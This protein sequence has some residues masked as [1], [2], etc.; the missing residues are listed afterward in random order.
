MNKESIYSVVET[1]TDYLN[2][3]LL[4]QSPKLYIIS[5]TWCLAIKIKSEM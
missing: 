2:H 1:I 4:Q 5:Q 3:P